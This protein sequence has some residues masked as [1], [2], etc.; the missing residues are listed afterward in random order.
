MRWLH[1]HA[2]AVSWL[3]V[4]AV[5]GVWGGLALPGATRAALEGGAVVEG[6]YVAP[7]AIEAPQTT[8]EVAVLAA[9]RIKYLLCSNARFELPE[10]LR[11]NRPIDLALVI[12]PPPRP[13]AAPIDAEWAEHID[14]VDWGRVGFPRAVEVQL[15]AASW[16]PAPDDFVRQ[17]LIAGEPARWRWEATPA[18]SDG[19]DLTALINYEFT[20]DG[21][22]YQRQTDVFFTP[23]V[24]G[25]VWGFVFAVFAG[26]EDLTAA[27]LALLFPAFAI[28]YRR[29][30]GRN[31]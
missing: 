5:W 11:E 6:E 9:A 27:L 19:R 8:D 22:S 31:S 26:A 29:V 16:S 1:D 18:Q 2:I 13:W 4:A 28:M 15:A 24:R 23:T 14:A 10:V 3:L 30:T 20:V 7:L 25:D 17:S 12:E 21:V